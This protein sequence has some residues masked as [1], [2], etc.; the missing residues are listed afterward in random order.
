MWGYAGVCGGLR[1]LRLLRWGWIGSNPRVV[2]RCQTLDAAVI[3]DSYMWNIICCTGIS[4]FIII[5][6]LLYLYQDVGV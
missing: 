2:A 3:V 1:G 5:I 6:L 4:M